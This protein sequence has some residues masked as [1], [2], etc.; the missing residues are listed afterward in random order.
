M[1]QQQGHATLKVITSI[2]LVSNSDARIL[3]DSG[4]THSFMATSYV[5]HL[6][7]ESKK[8]DNP[9]IVNTR[10]GETLTI[11][12]IYLNCVVMV[13]GYELLIDLLPLEMYDFD[14]ILGMDWLSKYNAVVDC[15]SK[16]VTFQKSGDLEFSFQGERKSCHLVVSLQ[17]QLRNVCRKD[18]LLIL[19]M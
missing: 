13:Q 7:G 2:L 18:I 1:T 11:D 12:A 3:I 9:M 6:G 4:A 15:F 17:W 10:M 14:V 19:S 16:T 5:M 8:L